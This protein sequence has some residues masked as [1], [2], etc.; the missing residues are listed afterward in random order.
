MKRLNDIIY[1]LVVDYTVPDIP[2]RK[3]CPEALDQNYPTM[4][5]KTRSGD[6]AHR[7][8]RAHADVLVE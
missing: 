8:A 5:R 2:R 6:Q 4:I 1:R 3:R 7:P